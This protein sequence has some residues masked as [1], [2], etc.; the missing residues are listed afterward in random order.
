MP[1]GVVGTGDGAVELV[2]LIS[3]VVVQYVVS[4]VPAPVVTP[5]PDAAPVPVVS[6]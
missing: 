3:S 2:V 5:A 6:V 4:V 1:G